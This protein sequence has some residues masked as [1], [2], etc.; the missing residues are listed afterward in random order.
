MVGILVVALVA[1]MFNTPEEVPEGIPEGTEAVTLDA[2]NHVEGPIDY[3]RAVPAG[4]PHNA[5]P[6]D[7]GVYDFEI[8]Q[9]NAVH[10]LEHAAVWITY[11]PEIGSDAIGTLESV[12]RTRT[13]TILSPVSDQPAPIMATAWGWQLQLDDPDDVRLRQ[14]VQTL[15][16]AGNAP[17]PGAACVGGVRPHGG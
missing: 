13:K 5:I 16:G 7:C 14:F 4:G 8:P 9:E 3:D 1:V 6:L 17:E 10:S 11:R 12:A 2:P 15:E